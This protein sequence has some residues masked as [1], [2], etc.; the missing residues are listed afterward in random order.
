MTNEYEAA[1]RVIEF[2]ATLD[3]FDDLIDN[4]KLAGNIA[5]FADDIAKAIKAE[6]LI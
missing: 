6:E 2:L 3:G 4:I 5:D 1:R